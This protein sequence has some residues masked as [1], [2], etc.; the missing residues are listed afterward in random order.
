MQTPR[1]EIDLA[2]IHHNTQTLVELFGS[3]G[4]GVMG[5]TKV[6]L[7]N[8]QVAKVMVRAGINL[9]GDSRI[10]N[11][12][13][14]LKAGVDA[15]FA[16]I[17]TPAVSKA[18]EVVKYADMSLNS[19]LAV[20]RRLSHFA[21]RLKKI[22]EVVLMVELGDLREGMPPDELEDTVHEMLSLP[23]IKLAGIGTNLACYSGVRP[24][25]QKMEELSSL[26]RS[27]E[28]KFSIA[29][30]VVSGGNSSNFEWFYE[31]DEVGRINNLRLGE[32]I[33]LGC[34]TL[35][36]KP[37][38]GLFPDVVTFV[39]EVIESKIKDSV[40]SGDIC[41]DAFGKVPS[42]EDRG[43]IRRVILGAGRQD[44]LVPGLT[45]L[46]DVDILGSSSDHIILDAR[47]EQLEV[48]D[49]VRFRLNYG[50]LLAA[51]TSPYVERTFLPL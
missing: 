45:P 6:V 32:S 19:E 42:F 36:R 7:G 33:F 12:R 18:E 10:E 31:E 28:D 3:R 50:A 2:K 29:L 47:K 48:G 23:G 1:L 27:V 37:I 30:D 5:I 43:R 46:S 17:R 44:V 14:M 40:P 38:R 15:K 35:N 26:A 39:T 41:Q 34:E 24:D 20:V 13:K 25:K 4:I 21:E 22:H 8:H 9:I 51:M 11:I 16:L 49:E